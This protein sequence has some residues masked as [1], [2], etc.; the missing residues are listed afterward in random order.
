MMRNCIILGSGRSGTSMAAGVL[1]KTGY[2]MGERLNPRNETN[3]KGQFEDREINRINEELLA[4]VTPHRPPSFL[5]KLFFRTRPKFGQ[6]WLARLPLETRIPSPPRLEKRM[7]FLTQR[8]PF[9]FKDPRFSYTLAAWRPFVKNVVFVC[10][11]RHPGAVVTSILKQKEKRPHLRNFSIN[12][13]QAFQVWEC[14]YSHILINHYP[15]GGDWLFLHYD[16]FFDGSACDK[17]EEG[18]RARVD[19]DFP[20]SGLNRSIQRGEVPS[21]ISSLYSQLCELAGYKE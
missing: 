11:F 6:R 10:V 14:M 12:P 19:R 8:E 3:P 1:N 15:K 13:N 18:L 20:E 7:R 2:F 9:C 5:G 21:Q 17:L 16:Q 4:H